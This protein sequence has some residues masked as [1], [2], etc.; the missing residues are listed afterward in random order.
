MTPELDQALKRLHVAIGALETALEN[1]PAPAD[2]R[3]TALE[4]E[5]QLMQ[6]DRARLAL[7][8]VC[9]LARLPRVEAATEH[10]SRRV[11]TA[12]GTLQEVVDE[13]AAEPAREV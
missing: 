12:I 10:V 11:D 7:V 8:L 3:R 1:R 9:V 6:D 2:E 13:E 4:T 5:L